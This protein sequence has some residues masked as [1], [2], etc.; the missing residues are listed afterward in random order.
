VQASSLP[1]GNIDP[2]G[3]TGTP[4]IDP[5]MQAVYFD[6]AVKRAK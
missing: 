4:V 5:A 1:C 2:L 3:I 6:A